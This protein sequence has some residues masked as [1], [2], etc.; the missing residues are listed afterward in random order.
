M[1]A[2]DPVPGPA[3]RVLTPRLVIRCLEPTDVTMLSLAVEQS[4]DHLLPWMS[5]VKQEPIEFQE[6]IQYL[7]KCRGKFDLGNDFVYGIFNPDETQFLGGTG[8]HTRPGEGAREIGYWIHKAYINQ[9]LATEVS[10]ALT[11]VAFEIE[12]VSRV[13]IHC[14]PKNVRSASVPRKLGYI[15]EATL[16]NRIED[17]DGNLRDSMIWTMFS[18]NYPT[19]SSAK[20]Q[21]EAYDVLGRRIL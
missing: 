4:L 17:S 2:S 3:Y 11:R 8:L 7:R 10:A 1:I 19:S 20:A 18:E 12:H 14:D 15:H 16:H 9:G 6:R 21:I 13:E 5:W